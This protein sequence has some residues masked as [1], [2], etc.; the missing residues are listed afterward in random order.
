MQLH[1]SKSKV[2]IGLMTKMHW[3][4]NYSPKRTLMYTIRC[5]LKCQHS[6]RWIN[7]VFFF[8]TK[9][10]I[11][12]IKSNRPNNSYEIITTPSSF[13]RRKRKMKKKTHIFMPNEGKKGRT[14]P[15]RRNW[16]ASARTVKQHQST[17]FAYVRGFVFVFF[18]A[19]EKRH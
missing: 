14:S 11:W 6:S 16:H 1:S 18:F 12:K 9:L 10:K 3:L 13:T 2:E 15:I 4:N 8:F 19:Y 7:R 17:A 5:I